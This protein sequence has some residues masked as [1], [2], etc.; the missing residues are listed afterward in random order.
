[1]CRSHSSIRWCYSTSPGFPS[2]KHL[3]G[4]HHPNESKPSDHKSFEMAQLQERTSVDGPSRSSIEKT[5]IEHVER[6]DEF[7]LAAEIL[8]RYPLLAGKSEEEMATLN[9]NVLKK[10]DWKFLV[11]LLILRRRMFHQLIVL[12]AMY[13]L[14]ASHEVRNCPVKTNE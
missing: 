12:L 10:L 14:H 4:L 8:S 13:H 11:S 9:K 7:G 5:K 2:F 3:S 1:L 6:A